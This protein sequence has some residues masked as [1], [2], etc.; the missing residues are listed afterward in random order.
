MRKG[1]KMSKDKEV[2]LEVHFPASVYKTLRA[3]GFDK[4]ALQEE[5]Q[6]AIAVRLFKDHRLSLGK[7]AELAGVSLIS[8]MDILRQFKVPIVEYGEDELAQDLKTIESLK[9]RTNQRRG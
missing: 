4:N 7:A 3:E 8:F 6:I 1:L 2:I 5:T 9:P